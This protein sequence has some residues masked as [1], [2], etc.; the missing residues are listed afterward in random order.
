MAKFLIKSPQGVQ[1]QIESD[2]DSAPTE[3]EL[4]KIYSSQLKTNGVE[5]NQPSNHNELT[6]F[7]KEKIKAEDPIRA[8]KWESMGKISPFQ[9]AQE[10]IKSEVGG[11]FKSFSDNYMKAVMEDSKINEKRQGVDRNKPHTRYEI[12][13]I[14]RAGQ[15]MYREIDLSKK[16]GFMEGLRNALAYNMPFIGQAAKGLDDKKEREIVKKIKNNENVGDDEVK[17]LNHR[18]DKRKE[19]IMRG[20]GIDGQIGEGLAETARLGG[21]LY[22]GGTVFKAL[23]GAKLAGAIPSKAGQWAVNTLGGGAVATLANPQ[24]IYANFQERMLNN[25]MKITDL[26]KVVFKDSEEKP[27][28]AF[29]KSLFGAFLSNATEIGGGQLLDSTFGLTGKVASNL[30]KKNPALKKLIEKSST[31]FAKYYEKV[32]NLPVV[33][34]SADWLSKRVH[35][36]G[37]LEEMGEESLEDI[38]HLTFGINNEDRSLENYTKAAFKSPEEWAVIAGTIAMYGGGVSMTSHLLN[39]RLQETNLNQEQID[40]ILHTSS[41]SEKVDLLEDMIQTNGVTIKGSIEYNALRHQ[42]VSAGRTDEQAETEIQALNRIDKVLLDKYNQDGE[43]ETLIKKRNLKALS[44]N[45]KIQQKREENFVSENMGGRERQT[46]RPEE[47][48][49]DAKAFQYKENSDSEGVTD[50]LEGIEEFDPLF[51]GDVI[52]YET[53]DGEKYIADGH[54]RLG[55]AKRLE[56]PNIKLSGY[57]F[58]ESDGFTP[59]KVRVLAAQK[60]IAEGSGTAIDTAK[61]I[62]EIGVENIP[63]SLPKNSA[64]VRNGISLARFGDEAF[65]KVINGDVTPQQGAVIADV[66]RN[67][68]VK[69]S[70]CIDGVKKARFENLEQVALFAQEVLS[71]DTTQSEQTNLFGTETIFETT[72]IEKIQIVDRAT[73]LLKQDKKIFTGLLR[74]KAKIESIGENELDSKTNEEVK[75][76]ADKAIT[77]I[78][79]LSCMRGEISDKANKLAKEYKDGKITFNHAV[80][81]FRD[82]AQSK[83]V[84]ESI[85]GQKTQENNLG[86]EIESQEVK[87]VQEI[88]QDEDLESDGIDEALGLK[89]LPLKGFEKESEKTAKKEQDEISKKES[90][91]KNSTTAD[92]FQNAMFNIEQFKD[93]QSMLF[94]TSDMKNAVS[95]SQSSKDEFKEDSR[96]FIQFR[97]D[98]TIIGLLEGHDASSVVHELAHLYLHD[99]Q[100]LAK[101]NKRAAKDLQ[102]VYEWLGRDLHKEYTEDEEREL[103]EKF[104]RGFEGYLMNGQAPTQRMQTLFDKFKIFLEDVYKHFEELGID[105]SEDVKRGFDRLFTTDEEYEK[106]VLPMYEQNYEMLSSLRPSFWE[107]IRNNTKNNVQAISHWWDALAIPIDTRLGKIDPKLKNII[108]KH[109]FDIM[110]INAK[111]AKAMTPFLETAQK[112]Q[113]ENEKDFKI[114]DLALKNR[115]TYMTNKILKKYNLSK[116]FEA[117]KD[118]LDSIYN[119]SVEV[120]LDLGYLE[121]YFPRLI[122][123]NKSEQFL[124]YFEKMALQEE[125]DIR[126]QIIDFEE[127]QYS[128]AIKSLR[129]ADPDGLWS[130][131]DKAKF[132]NTLIRGFGK[133][134]IMLS[135]I[136]QLKFERQIDKLTPELNAFYK[137]FTEAL[138]Y[139]I[140]SA[141]KN[142]EERKFFGGENKEVG[143]LRGTIKQKRTTLKEVKERTP[144][145]AK[146]KEATRLKYELSSVVIR[147][148]NALRSYSNGIIASENTQKRFS[149]VKDEYVPNL[150]E[151]KANIDK[152]G[153]QRKHLEEQIEYIEGENP[154]TVKNIVMRR[155]T[156]DIKKANEQIGLIIGDEKNIENSIGALVSSLVFNG[157][158]YAKDE[159]IIRDLLVAR[160]SNAKVNG[161]TAFIRDVGY[162]GTLNDIT[163][164]VTQFGDLAFSA[165]KFGLFDTIA[166]ARKVEGLT[167]KDLG[168]STIA[169]E[170][171]NPEGTAKAVNN[172][173]KWIGLEAIDGFGKNTVINASVNKARRLAKK[174]D[175]KLNE[176][177]KFMFGDEAKQVKQDLIDGNITDGVLFIAYS[178]LSD[179]QPISIDQMTEIYSKGGVYRLFYMLKTYS[180]KAVDIVR[181]DCFMKISEGTKTKNKSLIG[182]GL[183]NLA[184]LQFFMLM[185]GIP[186]DM[187]VD[188]ILN[189][190]FN[191]P[192]SVMDNLITSLIFNRFVKRT[193]EK[194]GLGSATLNYAIPPFFRMLD[195][196]TKDTMSVVQG[197]KDIKDAYGW[198]Y[199]PFAGKLYY[200]WLGGSKHKRVEQ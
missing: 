73:K 102:E 154:L 70:V 156:E 162:I 104:A 114:L 39:A 157:D 7:A 177:L 20:V 185:F 144:S 138:A 110:N 194:E 192:E 97:N 175:K 179:I 64:L 69:Q 15:P 137:S 56:D 81:Q 171:Q 143:K 181:N 100:E 36:D 8:K 140:P 180:I 167:R 121:N 80:M 79:K 34:K 57:V 115:D 24:S 62:K 67:D 5:Y 187:L 199:I 31:Q 195:T 45:N 44:I 84:L 118:I 193:F 163:N 91:E 23:G 19:Y 52:V 152:L 132:L 148:E 72:A 96:A 77:I 85:F 78:Q 33:G 59:E 2:G 42:L 119:E 159:K 50:R 136:G 160:F 116:D 122:D 21:E 105:F 90:R 46:F 55:L 174:D 18:I 22:F 125:I 103:H 170:F 155:L 6:S 68:E 13:G 54:Q 93:G 40:E 9:A 197:K 183:M 29:Y 17:F 10:T 169:E 65:Q 12:A 184:R 188:F 101:T 135:R 126:N 32:N 131:E 134:N 168:L 95:Y 150:E 200:N 88:E 66:I 186:K 139:Y 94:D 38:L 43:A 107:S 196:W 142:I 99:I 164:A 189:R 178:D 145:Q 60:N 191:L 61:I 147:H 182:E 117:V 11:F 149:G 41:E 25:E 14:D 111:D 161:A 58:K 1:F 124:D 4:N 49:T 63:K 35:F 53:K 176:K 26:G 113:R 158:I 76:D 27:A 130:R 127:A 74:N 48:N 198:A 89:K 165:Y 133:N 129:D 153:E 3:Q 141:R 166:G 51:A 123:N 30:M 109:T 75:L 173:L 83:E 28:T 108:K 128:N 146:F 37:L 106:E 71:A 47:L 120:G 190:E 82:Y 16:I 92:G 86:K 172:I 98:E 151:M 112:M 87:T